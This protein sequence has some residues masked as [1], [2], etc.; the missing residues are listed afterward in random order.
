MK[1]FATNRSVDTGVKMS[2]LFVAGLD[3]RL[4]EI[5][6][7]LKKVEDNIKTIIEDH[8][9]SYPPFYLFDD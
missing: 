3:E 6:E 4:Q 9:K 8:R 5:D 2:K 1:L 7:C